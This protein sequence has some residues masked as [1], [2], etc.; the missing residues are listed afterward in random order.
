M[1]PALKRRKSSS[2]NVTVAVL[3]PPG[4]ATLKPTEPFPVVRSTSGY[5][6]V[7]SVGSAE[8]GVGAT[9][10]GRMAFGLLPS[11]ASRNSVLHQLEAAQSGD[12]RTTTSSQCATAAFSAVCH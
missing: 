5:S 3:S 8:A 4:S 10:A 1:I 7:I 11:L 12:T 2:V 6:P 9:I